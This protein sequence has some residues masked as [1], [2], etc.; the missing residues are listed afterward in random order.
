MS[1]SRSSIAG[2]GSERLMRQS[3]CSQSIAAV[4][5]MVPDVESSIQAEE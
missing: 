5:P 2:Q 3:S 1:Y 4:Q